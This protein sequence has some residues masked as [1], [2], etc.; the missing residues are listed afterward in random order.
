[1]AEDAQGMGIGDW[2]RT[3]FAGATGGLSGLA[4]SPVAEPAWEGAAE[5]TGLEGDQFKSLA[6]LL[7]A[8]GAGGG[9]LPLLQAGWGVAKQFSTPTQPRWWDTPASPYGADYG[10]SDLQGQEMGGPSYLAQPYNP[11]MQPASYN[12]GEVHVGPGSQHA[13]DQMMWSQ[14]AAPFGGGGLLDR[15][16]RFSDRRPGIPSPF[17][18]PSGMPMPSP[19]NDPFAR[20]RELLGMTQTP[21]FDAVRSRLAM[22][23]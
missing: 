8:A 5:R 7:L 15:S 2:L 20:A 1:M 9:I 17:G 4:F 14:P 11:G 3:L 13:V 10:R 21:D 23:G 12:R 16:S 19:D 18:A 22:G 6:R